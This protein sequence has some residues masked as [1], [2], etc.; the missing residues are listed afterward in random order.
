M[1]VEIRFTNNSEPLEAELD[2]KGFRID[3]E[4]EEEVFGWFGDIYIAIKK[5]LILK[6]ALTKI[7]N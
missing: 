7:S 2:I 1:K 4:T 5:D 6:D 3:Y